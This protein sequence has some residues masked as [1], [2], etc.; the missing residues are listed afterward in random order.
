MF[1]HYQLVI[2]NS[3]GQEV[4]VLNLDAFDLRRAD[5]RG[6]LI[7]AIEDIIDNDYSYGPEAEACPHGTPSGIGCRACFEAEHAP[8]EA[9]P[10]SSACRKQPY[11][12]RQLG[13]DGE[14]SPGF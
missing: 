7:G 10:E 3:K 6:R 14:C 13:H 12:C 1:H 5:V 4:G 9:Q 11:C 2:R 8:D